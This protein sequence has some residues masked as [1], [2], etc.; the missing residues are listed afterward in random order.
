MHRAR[1]RWAV[2]IGSAM[3][4]LL[5][6][7]ATADAFFCGWGCC[8]GG[9]CG[10]PTTAMSPV[11]CT[12]PAPYHAG[13]MMW[14]PSY[15]ITSTC[16]PLA[17][18]TCGYGLQ[19]CASPVAACGPCATAMAPV[20]T[21]TYRPFLWGLFRPLVPA[22]TYR[23][24][25]CSPAAPCAPACPTTACAPWCPAPACPTSCAPACDPCGGMAAPALGAP[26]AGY[27][28]IAPGC[29]GGGCAPVT[30]QAPMTT[31]EA[32]PSAGAP[33]AT[34]QN[35]IVPRTF[36]PSQPGTEL[37][38]SPTPD[39]NTNGA[40]P[41]TS[42]PRLIDPVARKL[43]RPIHQATY[44][45]PIARPKPVAAPPASPRPTVAQP[46]AKRS[47]DVGGWRASRN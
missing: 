2:G 9:A 33:A 19:S 7:T 45:V 34:E 46:P 12:T 31:Y 23:V 28:T 16:N 40:D 18:G 30:A 15:G 21:T 27:D 35:S 42:A 14:T 37:R 25:F 5:A 22:T 29:P 20:A 24:A 32:A 13:R 36:E 47:V 44:V 43:A 17:P 3:I 6:M 26:S 11:C 39:T 8:G 4:V 38:M 1:I 10:R 41:S